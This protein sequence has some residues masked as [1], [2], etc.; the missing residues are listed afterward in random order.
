MPHRIVTFEKREKH[1][2]SATFVCPGF[3][4]GIIFQTVVPR[5]G[6]QSEQRALAELRR[7]RLDCGADGGDGNG[8]TWCQRGRS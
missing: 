7:L 8:D 3:L 2:V 1:K 6:S 5:S 4:P